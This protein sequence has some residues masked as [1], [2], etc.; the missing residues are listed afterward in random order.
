[1]QQL[2]LGDGYAIYCVIEAYLGRK[3]FNSIACELFVLSL[4]TKKR[5]EKAKNADEL[6]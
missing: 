3:K 4:K 1:M 5:L 6:G 2:I